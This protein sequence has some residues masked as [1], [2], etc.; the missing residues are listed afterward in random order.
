MQADFFRLSEWGLIKDWCFLVGTKVFLACRRGMYSTISRNHCSGKSDFG[1]SLYRAR[2]RLM[3][4]PLVK[5]PRRGYFYRTIE[6]ITL[7]MM[8]DNQ[9]WSIFSFLLGLC[10]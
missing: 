4:I 2:S 3:C 8:L 1:S 7:G 10:L 5:L 6:D 9:C